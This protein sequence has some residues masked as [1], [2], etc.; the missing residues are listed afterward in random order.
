MIFEVNFLTKVSSQKAGIKDIEDI[1]QTRF[2]A[3]M[4]LR[5]DKLYQVLKMQRRKVK[6]PV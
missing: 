1:R 5:N 3:A 2:I 6:E 4:A